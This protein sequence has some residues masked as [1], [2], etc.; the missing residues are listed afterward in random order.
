LGFDS[1]RIDELFCAALELTSA[2]TRH[3]FLAQHCAGD[4]ELLGRLEQLIDAHFRAGDFMESPT[5]LLPLG[6]EAEIAEGPGSTIGRYKLLQQIGEGGF[7]VVFLAEQIEPVKRRV[8]LKVI[9]QGMDTRKVVARFEGERQALAMMEHPGIA[10]VLDAGAT[11]TGLPYFVMELVAGLPITEY[12][13]EKELP[14]RERLEL[15]RQVCEA[16]QHAHQKGIIHRDIK[17]SN[18]LVTGDSNRPVAKVIDFGVAKAIETPLGDR[19]LFTE[20][21]QLVGTPAY[22]SPEQADGSRDI[23]TRSDVYSLGVLLYELLAGAPPFD[24]RQLQKQEYAE[25]QR[26]ICEVEPPP[27]SSRLI[28]ISRAEH[29]PTDA[30]HDSHSDSVAIAKSRSTQPRKLASILRGELDWIVLRCL[31]KERGR[32]YHSASSLAADIERYLTNQ[33]V[34]ARPANWLYRARKFSRRNKGLLAAT[35]LI[36]ISFC[37]GIV[38]TTWQAIRATRAEQQARANEQQAMTQASRAEAISDFLIRAFR[39]PDPERDGRTITIVEVLERTVSELAAKYQDDPILKAAILDALSKTY[40]SLGLF[41]KAVPLSD[42]ALR[43]RQ[44]ALGESH[45]ETLST[46]QT[47]AVAYAR[48]GQTAASVQLAEQ[49]LELRKAAFGPDDVETIRAMIS[50]SVICRLA[51]QPGKAMPLADAAAELFAKKLGPEEEDTL[52]ARQEVLAA[53]GDAMGQGLVESMPF[54]FEDLLEPMLRTLGEDH[55]LSMVLMDNIGL[56]DFRNRRYA[57]ARRVWKKNLE[58]R[59]AKLGPTHSDTIR[60]ARHLAKLYSERDNPRQALAEID[61]LAKIAPEDAEL[62][63]ART[64]TLSR[65][66]PIEEIANDYVEKIRAAQEGAPSWSPRKIVCLELA[67]NPELFAAVAKLMPDETALWIGRGQYHVLHN[68]LSEAEAD[69]AR[70]IDKRPL[71]DEH[72]E[73]GCLLLLGGDNAAYQEFCRET[74]ERNREFKD[75]YAP[76]VLSRLLTLGPANCVSSDRLIELATIAAR[77]RKYWEL[78]A[79]GLANL[80]AGRLTEAIAAY[81]ESLE[82]KQMNR[83]SGES[84]FGL[85]IA[86]QKLGKTAQ[87]HQALKQG[88]DILR[89]SQ[90][91][92]EDEPARVLLSS[93]WLLLN[94]MAGE[95]EALLGQSDA[96]T[97]EADS[98]TAQ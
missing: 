39:S 27:P 88:R 7:G 96:A 49:V 37:V 17:P 22:M 69:F 78:Q 91:F 41:K 35:L 38:A 80:R 52:R 77:R 36:L 28:T 5:A 30:Y 59:L 76:F 19:T 46:M 33:P 8:A 12:C 97:G 1:A 57:S 14:I 6:E 70:V 95:A 82:P 62:Q 3:E 68:R 63:A 42:E 44:Q 9:K 15:F 86:F 64:T 31:E 50:L 53:Y 98:T 81:E 32:R 61:D 60:T 13:D 71:Q 85:A 72:F 75:G 87:A 43:L 90:P 66:R 48:T 58:L 23:D 65:M 2:E 89:K 67:Y 74:F 45:R 79:L 18:V 55:P 73:Y 26:I 20:L 93:T 51:D 94:R 56:G 11:D 4:D 83:E 25:M 16:V 10:K 47:L 40:S 54:D 21:R 92:H 34:E 84:Y 24:P 29:R